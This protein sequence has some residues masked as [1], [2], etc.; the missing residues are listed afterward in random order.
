MNSALDPNE[1]DEPRPNLALV[2]AGTSAVA[3]V[4]LLSLRWPAAVASTT[5]GALMIAGAEMDARAFL[6]PD[7]VTFGASLAGLAAAAL[8]AAEDPLFAV[9]EA[10]VGALCVAG[11]FELVRRIFARLRGIEGLGLGDVKLA[12]AIGAWLPLEFA[13]L[14]I[15]L[16]AGAALV[17]VGLARLRGVRVDAETRLPFGAYLCPALWLAY[18]VS[19]LSA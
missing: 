3:V 7:H 13:P 1:D 8:L 14:C 6:L 2:I 19:A 17:A 16:A 18:F 15:I 4:S 11:V 10:A 12:A 9:L 5:L